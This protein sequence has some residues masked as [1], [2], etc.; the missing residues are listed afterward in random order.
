[1]E[2]N[3]IFPSDFEKNQEAI[4]RSDERHYFSQ[5]EKAAS[6]VAEKNVRFVFLA[7]PSCSGKTTTALTLAKDLEQYGKRVASFSTDDF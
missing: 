6:Y 2:D 7:G 4:V 3:L 5:I 1:M